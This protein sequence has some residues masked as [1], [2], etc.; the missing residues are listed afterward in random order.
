MTQI[1]Q[2]EPLAP[3]AAQMPTHSS[4]TIAAAP[5][6][7]ASLARATARAGSS[8]RGAGVGGRSSSRRSRSP[9]VRAA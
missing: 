8:A 5:A 6:R 1:G 3:A 2:N 7:W 9:W 4:E